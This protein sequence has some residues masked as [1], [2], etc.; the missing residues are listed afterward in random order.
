MKASLS[1]CVLPLV[2]LQPLFL[3]HPV[4]KVKHTGSH[5]QVFQFITSTDVLL[6]CLRLHLQAFPLCPL[7]A[8]SKARPSSPPAAQPEPVLRPSPSTQERLHSLERACLPSCSY[9]PD[10]RH[11][12]SPLLGCGL[13]AVC[14]RFPLLGHPF[15]RPS[16]LSLGSSLHDLWLL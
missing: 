10:T 16:T 3:A 11:C 13:Q 9:V 7:S 6:G 1:L 15:P 2:P 4:A 14:M 12:Q 8:F 5:T